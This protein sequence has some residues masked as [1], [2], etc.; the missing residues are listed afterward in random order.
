MRARATLLYTQTNSNATH[1][2]PLHPSPLHT[3]QQQPESC[4]ALHTTFDSTPLQSVPVLQAG[5]QGPGY[6]LGGDRGETIGRA[7]ARHK[8]SPPL[9][10]A[11]NVVQK[12]TP[13]H[14]S[15][16]FLSLLLWKS[17]MFLPSLS[18]TPHCPLS[19]PGC[20]RQCCMPPTATTYHI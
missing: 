2:Y 14:L 7:M 8:V 12:C 18:L 19:S 1:P 10:I 3:V 16:P 13:L 20:S 15:M 9:Y 6:T 17:P 4:Q 11:W 5:G